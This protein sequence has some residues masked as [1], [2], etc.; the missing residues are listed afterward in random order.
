MITKAIIKQLNTLNDNHFLVYIPLLRKANAPES[1]ATL[2][3]T[4]IVLPGVENSLKVDDVVFVTFE[5]NQMDKPVIL[6]KLYTGKEDNITTNLTVK[7]LVSLENTDLQN[8]T[9]IENIN[10]TTLS[11][12]LNWLLSHNFLPAVTNEDNELVA[13]SNEITY[14]TDKVKSLKNVKEALDYIIG[15]LS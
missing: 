4:L 13:G 9:T 12:Q 15:K 3:A 11:T 5:D 1:S 14:N 6:G 8:N 2:S 10:L 7:S